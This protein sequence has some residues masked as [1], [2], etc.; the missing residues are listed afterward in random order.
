MDCAT[1]VRTK[2]SEPSIQ[3]RNEKVLNEDQL[4]QGTHQ[5]NEKSRL[6]FIESVHVQICNGATPPTSSST[7]FSGTLFSN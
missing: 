3:T 4:K 2:M 7:S 1:T 5:R 6:G